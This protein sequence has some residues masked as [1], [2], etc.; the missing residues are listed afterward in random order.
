MSAAPFPPLPQ[1]AFDIIYADP[2]WDYKGQLQH[3][4]AGNGTTGGATSHYRTLTLNQL[5]QLDVQSIAAKNCLLFLWTSSPHLD[6]AIRLGRE[7]GFSWSTVAFVWDKQKPNPGY[8]TMS[9]CELCLVFKTGC[10]PQPRGS[11]SERQ[12]ISEPR[13]RHSRKPAGVRDSIAAMFPTQ[14]RIEL[15]ARDTAEGWHGWGLDSNGS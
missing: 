12:F 11:M 14:R 1:E 4:G 8:Y 6:Q 3:A 5:G 9:Q 13:G 7:W 2:P 15:F 10:I